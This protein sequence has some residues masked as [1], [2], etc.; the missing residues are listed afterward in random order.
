M[1]SKVEYPALLP[2][3]FHIRTIEQI[4]ALCVTNFPRSS[5]RKDLMAKL[6]IAVARI[7]AVRVPSELWIDGSFL[8]VKIDPDDVDFALIVPSHVSISA[9][10][11]VHETLHWL[12]SD[13]T[14]D[15]EH[16]DGHVLTMFPSSSPMAVLWHQNHE[17][18]EGVFGT[19]Y[20]NVTPK[21]IVVMRFFGGV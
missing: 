11:E 1:A 8:T 14:Y 13:D 7:Q 16:L 18:W 2:G 15:R 20:D 17:K 10:K 19:K 3:G 21:G 4:R 5:T 6:E 12:A 9:T